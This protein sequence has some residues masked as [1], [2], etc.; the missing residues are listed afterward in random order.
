MAPSN[1]VATFKGQTTGQTRAVFNE[2][3]VGALQAL[4]NVG[5]ISSPGAMLNFQ[6][7]ASILGISA[8]VPFI[9]M[10]AP[11]PDAP[12]VV[13]TLRTSDPI[14][15]E[16]G[17]VWFNTTESVFKIF[18]TAGGVEILATAANF[19]NA[20]NVLQ[21]GTFKTAA[22]TILATDENIALDTN[23]GAFT[24]SMPAA[25]AD[26]ETHRLTLIQGAS[27]VTI[28]GNGN[29]VDGSATNALL[30][31]SA[32]SSVTLQYLPHGFNAWAVI[33]TG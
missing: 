30:L 10:G 7:F 8:D 31:P 19:T 16:V 9:R 23:G 14:T 21:S 25:P 5:E 24:V 28:D 6:N 29:N 3:S 26:Y 17:G 1:L 12:D 22:Y 13:F 4:F 33:G 20:N 27:A 32:R 18:T 11:A 2:G 15:P